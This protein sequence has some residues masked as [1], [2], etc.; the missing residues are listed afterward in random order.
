MSLRPLLPFATLLLLGAA[1]CNVPAT[2]EVPLGPFEYTVSA[3]RLMLPDAFRDDSTMTVRTV[4]CTDDTQCPPLGAG[5]PAVHCVAS[6][7]DPDPFTFVLST[8]VIDLDTQ[9]TIQTFGQSITRIELR[10]ASYAATSQG[11]QN[12]VGPTELYWAPPSATATDSPGVQHLGTIPL[13]QLSDGTT[14]MGDVQIDAD[15]GA[16]LSDY[17]LH[18]AH[19]LRVFAV[20]SVDLAPG[21]PLPVGGVTLDLRFTVHVEGQLVR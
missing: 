17:L 18:T 15:G 5:Q 13:V 2:I 16:A 8:D 6:A 12:P 20:P 4:P 14:A 11:L 10:T 1:A 7:C 21:G 3:S 9:P 19:Q